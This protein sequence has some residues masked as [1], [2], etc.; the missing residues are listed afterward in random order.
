MLA[1]MIERETADTIDLSNRVSIEI[2]TA[3][4]RSVRGYTVVAALCDEI[5]YWP[6]DDGANPDSEILAAL[7]PAMATIPGALLLCVSSPYARRGAMWEAYRD[8]YGNDHSPALVWQADTRTMNPT[9]PARVV[10]EAYARD[11]TSAAAEYGAEFRSDIAAFLPEEW[12]M[13]AATQPHELPPQPGVSYCAFADP[14]GGGSDAFTF[15]IAHQEEGG[16]VVLNALR[17]RRPPFSPEAVVGEYVALLQSYGL[18]E[19]TGDRYAGQWVVDAFTKAG[20]VYRHSDK[21]KSDIYLE[22]EPLFAQGAVRLI[23]DRHLLTELRQLERRTA[24]GGKDSVDHPPRGHD[25]LANAACGALWLAS[26]LSAIDVSGLADALRQIRN[27]CYH[28]RPQL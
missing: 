12:I 6:T 3:S 14:S 4:F 13:A 18:T 17:A 26:R 21:S 23:D 15:A 10:D 9:V 20:V 11:P 1:R 19:V 22:T 24:R 7:R 16:A 5:A 2:H 25:D 27:Y 8:H 28:P